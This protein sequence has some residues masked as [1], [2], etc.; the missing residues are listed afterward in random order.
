VRTRAE[1]GCSEDL[2]YC[3]VVGEVSFD[4]MFL[5]QTIRKK[6]GKEHRYFS[7][8]ENKRVADGRVVQRHVLY[9]GEIND[10]QQLAW[11]KSIEVF[12]EGVAQPRMLSLFPEDRCEGL[13]PDASI[14]RLKLSQ[15]RLCRSR[16]WGACWLVLVLW[17]GLQ[18]DR[19]WAERLPA[20]R[21]GTRWDQVLLVLVAYRLL[22]P[23]SEW[24]LHRE[25]FERSALADLLGEDFALAEIHKLY[26]CHDRLLAHKN[27][28]FDHLVG[29]WRDLFNVSFDVL[30]YDL[31]S[32]YFEAD[33]PFPEGDKR[34]FGYS[35]D[36][37][38]DCVQVVIALVVTAEGLPL[39]YEVLP[40]NT[41]DNTTLRGF[42]DR[43]E[44]Q[45][46][47]ARRIW[48][49]DRGVPTE[50]VLAEMRAANPPVQY[51]VGTPKGRLTRLERELLAKPWQEARP[52]VQVKLLPQDG[53]LYV[54]AQSRDRVAKE[55]AMRRRQLKWLWRRLA[56][57]AAMKLTREELLMKLGA[58]RSQAPT[59][60]RLVAVAV[61][62]TGSTFSYRLDRN[63][64]RQ[65][66]RR[67]GRYLLRTNLT[68]N[69]PAQ[70]W[71]YYLQ[72]VA[73]EEAF[74][75]LKGDLAIRPI[76]HQHEDRVEAHIFIAFLAYCLH[77]T[78][79][80][81][82]HALAPGL[83]TR[84]VIKKFAAL[85]MIDVHVPT[86]DGRELVLTR[87]TEPEPEL[88]LLLEK[89]RLQLPAQPPPKI[90]AE[91][92]SPQAAL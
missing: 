40:G 59:A 4:G 16:Q 2:P 84:S 86:T 92:P 33:P 18:L 41:A 79:G 25:W 81:R 90:T 75:N 83:T 60:W 61:P 64:L 9:L 87:H 22:A 58:A 91:P 68:E 27:D 42:L 1:T 57:I 49:M 56:Q 46:G 5:R 24:H 44:R 89:L 54:F 74:K 52:G 51:V 71:G 45:Y 8:V 77:V 48:L 35:R 88:K 66:R 65:A 21:K 73:V 7:V 23:G 43:I 53:E 67:E 55:R 36:H 85:Q 12:E 78:L 11:R 13:L 39:A 69:D 30:L 63:K 20:S 72:L 80:R 28:L 31:T 76:F 6:D 82:L 29:R 26:T 14:V 34:R 15:V 19:F 37:R 10:T 47:K 38:P 17:Q 50:E 32:S 62:K 70:L 3:A